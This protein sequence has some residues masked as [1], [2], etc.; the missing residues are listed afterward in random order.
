LDEADNNLYEHGGPG[1]LESAR[2]RVIVAFAYWVWCQKR[3][4]DMV[5]S[6]H[7]FDSSSGWLA[8]FRRLRRAA[9]NAEV[10]WVTA[11]YG[12]K[13]LVEKTAEKSAKLEN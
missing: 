12:F 5:N 3:L 2:L 9:R 10:R 6:F 11:I 8:T 7:R 1:E 4:K 13:R